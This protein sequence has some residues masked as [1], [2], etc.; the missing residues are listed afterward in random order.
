MPPIDPETAPLPPPSPSPSP[1]P[2]PLPPPSP[3]PSAPPSP[4]P[5]APPPPSP[6][7]RRGRKAFEVSPELRKEI[8]GLVPLYRTRG[9]ARR[10][11][12]DRKIVERVLIEEGLISPSPQIPKT[13]K[14]EPFY[15]H[16]EGLVA[17]RISTTRILREIRAIGYKGC[18]TILAERVREVQSRLTLA[19]RHDV[20]CRFETPPG[21]E[22][23]ID[24]S[25][26]LVPIAGRVVRIHALGCLL[27]CCRK[28]SLHFYRDERESTLLEALALAFCEFDGVTL[29][30]VL[31]NMTTAVL[32]RIGPDRK[33]LW[34]SRFLDFSRHYGFTPY[35][36]AVRDPD[37][38]GKKEKSFRLV[39]DD[40]LN[41]SEFASWEDLDE[42]RRI[43]LDETPG[44]A[45]L[46]VHATTRLVPNRAFE[47]EHPLLIRLPGSSF[48]VHDQEI[49]DADRDS[50]IWVRGTPYSIPSA[51]ANHSVAVRLFSDHFEVLDRL[52]RIA[53]SRRYVPESEKGRL[54]IDPTHYAS[55]ARRRSASSGDRLD[56][57]F[58]RRF[59]QLEALV[60]GIKRRA[61]TLAPIHFR[62]LIRLADR[63]SEPDFLAAAS[64]AQEFRRFDA[65]AIE[66]ILGQ[67]APPPDEPVPPL[68]GHGPLILGEVDP[69]ALDSFAQ[70][71][72]ADPSPT[73]EPVP[74]PSP[75]TAPAPEP[76]PSTPPVPQPGPTTEPTPQPDPTPP[77]PKES[78]DGS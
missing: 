77:P 13:S 8:L 32:G 5:P 12:L 14:L 65:L 11:H 62:A 4:P 7:P 73:T 31:D 70:F 39:W 42:R 22:M 34:H 37:R 67:T 75:T 3:P 27:A 46:R 58:L 51:L 19:P 38:K 69:G 36:C 40:F 74:E 35:A 59:P 66:R 25:S 64:R 28:L 45:N 26:Y 54:V 9:I 55:L 17:K 49:R 10:V 30:V 18:R 21:K 57:A 6:R 23:Q 15:D 16:V 60:D 50:T 68:C 2:S 29:Y 56:E 78:P 52:G 53:F 41:G 43:W 20:K 24:W 33:P 76:G 71:D 48:P 44:V 1:P 47:D 61:K 63:Y 72:A